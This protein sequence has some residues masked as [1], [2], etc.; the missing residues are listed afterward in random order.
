MYDVLIIGA[1]VNGCAIAR[2]LS[3]YRLRIGVIEKCCDL[4]EGTTKANSCISHAGYDAR[5]GTLKARLNVRGNKLLEEL[6]KELSFLYIKCGSLV[7]CKDKEGLKELNILMER[8]IKNNVSGLRILNADEVRKMEPNLNDDIYAA[9]YAPDAAIM[10]GFSLNYNLGYSA[11]INGVDFV[12]DTEVIGIDKTDKGYGLK[13]VK[14]PTAGRNNLCDDFYEARVV[15]NAAGIYADRIH[16]M[17][18]DNPIEI[19]P[20]R[21]EYY[22]FDDAFGWPV[23]KVIFPL[24]DKMGK[25]SLLIPLSHGNFMVGPS[26]EDIDDKEDCGTDKDKLEAVKEKSLSLC[27]KLPFD[28]VVRSFSGLRAHVVKNEAAI[29]NYEGKG[30][31][32]FIIGEL[33]DAPGFIDVAGMESPGLTCAPA[34]G[35]YVAEI[36]VNILKPQRNDGFIKEYRADMLF[37]A[38]DEAMR[39]QMI[40][41]NP[42]HGNIICRCCTTTEA[43]IVNALHAP[44]P[45]VTVDGVKKR[46]GAGMGRCQGGFCLPRV[47]DIISRELDIPKNCVTMKGKGSNIIL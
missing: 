44:I 40:K 38:A 22:V 17:I 30:A 29:K 24:P 33:Q 10:D 4:C 39:E 37:I 18:S 3:K 13:V 16:N 8:G 7:V 32:D 20:R 5:E 27:S 36:V 9:L 31:D 45:A 11:K 23:S 21:G 42:K 43:D 47:V 28:M 46:C 35:E 1:G 2:E 26:A 34:T 19:R 15:I 25:G 12:F 41:D 6:S 14:N